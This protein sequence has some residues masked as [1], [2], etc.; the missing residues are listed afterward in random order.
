MSKTLIHVEQVSKKFSQ[1]IRHTMEYGVKDILRNAVGLRTPSEL[2]RGEFW[3]VDNIS[4]DV[5]EGEV[6]GIIG[7][8]G[9]G[10]STTLKMLNGIYNPDR[11]RIQMNGRTGALIELGAGFHPLLS[12]RENIYVNGAILGMTEAEIL[13]RIDDIIEFSELSEGFINAPVRTYSSGMRARLGFSIVS[14][15]QCD[16]LLIDEV[17][18]VGDLAFQNKC[19]H[20]LQQMKEHSTVVIVSHNLSVISM[21]CDRVLWLEKGHTK[22]LGATN[23]VVA[24]YSAYTMEQMTKAQT[25]ISNEA[26]VATGQV[27][28]KDIILSAST[29]PIVAGDSVT[30]EIVYEVLEALDR[31]HFQIDITSP[32]LGVICRAITLDTVDITLDGTVGVHHLVCTFEYFPLN[33][34][35]Y[36]IDIHIYPHDLVGKYFRQNSAASFDVVDPNHY[37]DPRTL[38]KARRGVLS[39]PYKWSNSTRLS[40]PTNNQ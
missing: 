32:Q 3:A 25:A 28:L 10:K 38:V 5:N 30:V 33:V 27:L 13:E 40:I 6:L 14:Q 18:A 31:P 15:L 17:L 11:G 34:G 35:Q 22:A 29:Q 2:R 26:S 4:F 1:G 37:D 20:H 24:Q 23:E 9:S 16:I 39:V 19:Y 21:L 7:V 36:Y 12:G 8:N